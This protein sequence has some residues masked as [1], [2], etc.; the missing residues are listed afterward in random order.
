MSVA[1]A[2]GVKAQYDRGESVGDYALPVTLLNFSASGGHNSIILTW[3][4]ASEIDLMGFN[5]CRS[6]EPEEGFYRI[7]PTFIPAMG[8]GPE[9]IEYQYVDYEVD[10]G[11]L[12]Y[13]RLLEV[14][15]NG[16]ETIIG[17]TH[18][19]F[20]MLQESWDSPIDLK[21]NYPE[22]FNELT[23]IFF[24][25]YEKSRVQLQ[26]YDLKG[27]KVATVLDR[28]LSPGNYEEPF[29]GDL[30]PSGIYFCR[31]K[32]ENGFET[33]RKMVLLH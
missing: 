1:L 19:S 14:G 12:Y 27:R 26:I 11:F 33:V 13:Y 21:G 22:P 18:H 3:M 8:K 29:E 6:M 16:Q 2:S 23:R 20:T 5:L 7:N 10:N 9:L 32:G 24:S 15:L 17:S 25:V 31:L 30:F 4:T 28:I